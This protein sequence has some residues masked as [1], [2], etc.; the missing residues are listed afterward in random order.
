MRRIQEILPVEKTIWEPVSVPIAR[1]MAFE[2]MAR[3]FRRRRWHG[4]VLTPRFLFSSI[5]E[6]REPNAGPG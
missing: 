1:F 6:H 2:Q 4:T 3:A 5:G